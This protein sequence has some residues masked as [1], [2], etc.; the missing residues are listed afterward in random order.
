LIPLPQ[1]ASELAV[2]LGAALFGANALALLR[3][4]LGKPSGTKGPAPRPPST[5]KVVTN[6]V[7]GALVAV[8]GVASLLNVR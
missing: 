4:H 7:I 1:L 8:I 5:A 2:G 6:M 3:P